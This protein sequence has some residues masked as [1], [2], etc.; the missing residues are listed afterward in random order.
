[1]ATPDCITP[2]R[3]CKTCKKPFPRTP[4]F[5]HKDK[6]T[7]DGLSFRCKVCACAMSNK[8]RKDNPEKVVI[9][10][11]QHPD[12]QRQW[13]RANRDSHLERSRQHYRANPAAKLLSGKRWT[14]ANRTVRRLSWR[15][16]QHK[17]RSWKRQSLEQHTV[18]DIQTL[19]TQQN[20]RCWWCGK[21]V[22]AKYHVDHRIPLARGGGNGAS[23]LVISCPQCNW[24]KKA[25]MPWEWNGRLL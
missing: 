12:Y 22:G 25:K 1:M 15:V 20:G 21:P 17:R 5:W 14:A 4:E 11:Q 6:G 18:K 9:W 7:Y 2:Q 8:W 3:P 19:Y 23:N 13:Y 24:S 16:Y 10:R